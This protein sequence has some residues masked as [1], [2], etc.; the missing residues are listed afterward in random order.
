MWVNPSSCNTPAPYTQPIKLQAAHHQ[1]DW[2]RY[3]MLGSNSSSIELQNSIMLMSSFW[4]LSCELGVC[5]HC[6][7]TLSFA[8]WVYSVLD[9]LYLWLGLFSPFS[10]SCFLQFFILFPQSNMNVLMFIIRWRI[11][12]VYSVR[13]VTMNSRCWPVTA[14]MLHITCIVLFRHS[15]IC[16]RETGDVPCV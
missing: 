7:D 14:V 1:A 9:E 11:C 3:H 10:F 6:F 16:L 8:C 5:L 13:E 12:L 15:S 2:L 4:M